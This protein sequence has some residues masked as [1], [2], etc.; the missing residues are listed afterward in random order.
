M[1]LDERARRASD[2][3]VRDV[4]RGSASFQGDPFERFERS[5]ARRARN[6]RVTA[7]VVASGLALLAAI[8]LARTFAADRTTPAA[9]LP[10]GPILYGA[11]DQR[12]QLAH[13]YTVLPDGSDL[14]DLHLDASCAAWFPDPCGVMAPG[15]PG[16]HQR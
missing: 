14:Q 15:M 10:R 2:D 13:W 12:T 9:P 3:L 8:F 11:W 7:A 16:M 1:N 6:Q 4:D 5:V